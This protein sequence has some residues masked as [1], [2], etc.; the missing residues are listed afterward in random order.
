MA[1]SRLR[2]ID[3]DLPDEPGDEPV[4]PATPR[5]HVLEIVLEAAA[6]WLALAAFAP[7]FAGVRTF[8]LPTVVATVLATTLAVLARR[9]A[10]PTRFALVGSAVVAGLFVSYTILV[11]SLAWGVFPGRDTVSGLRRGIAQGFAQML[12]DSLP[13]GEHTLALVFV[14]LLGWAAAT[15][16]T[17]LVLRRGIPAL[18]LVVP[19]G[20]L[21]IAMPVVAPMHPPSAW[22]VG[23]LVVL[24]LVLALV[25]AVPDPEATG[26]LIGPATDGPAEFHSRSQVGA[27]LSLGL[28]FLVVAAL[29]AP[30]AADAVTSRRAADPRSLRDTVVQPLRVDDPLAEYARIVG[31]S[32]A[33]P[34]FQVT[35]QGATVAEVAR[36]A[37]VRLDTYDGVRFTTSD[38][39]DTAG[40]VLA[41][42]ADRPSSGRDVVLRFRNL[43]LDAPWLPTAGTP[44]RIDLRGVGYDR[45]S[46]DVLAPGTVNGLTYELQARIP[47]ATTA[48]LG[49]TPVDAGSDT[50]ADRAL[51]GGLPPNLGRVANEVT[52]GSLSPAEALEKLASYLR[53][54]FALDP[55][56]PSGHAAGRLDQFLRTDRAGTP[57]QF[58]TAFAV[59]ARS[60][61]Y[62]TRVVVGYKLLAD[63]NGAARPLEFVTTASYHVWAEVAYEGLGWI[64]YDP[65]PSTGGPAPA[66]G[67]DAAP[68]PETVTP[69][70]GGDQRTPRAVGPSEADPSEFAGSP[71][72]RPVAI[73]GGIAGG[74][75]LLVVGGCAAVIGAKLLRRR[76]RRAAG[77][78][79]GRV[80]GA[81]DE[82]V[83][84]LVELRFPIHPSMTPRDIARAT[85]AVYGTAAT[86]PLGFLVPD[87][88][89]AVFGQVAP[90]DDTADRSWAR[91]LEFE[92]NLAI[93]LNGRQRWRARLSLRPFGLGRRPDE[94]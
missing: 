90:D 49:A 12:A 88:G 47:T 65:T 76:R 80:V 4:R 56:A 38:E 7:V 85:Q 58:A 86:L 15:A 54:Q 75:V 57:E 66:R 48:D 55:R 63:D 69:T 77:D 29:V 34:A 43:D 23:G 89:R 1:M 78:A 22:H 35:V 3:E 32:P 9:R 18:P 8:V 26:T 6:C 10:V 79:A 53:T 72:W 30:V 64:P 62:P 84:R 91:A 74:A 13:L 40:P 19:L 60:L 41:Q 2:R 24:L 93:T 31:L 28:P 25:R 61:G 87:V 11:G 42:P 81:W 37:V 50:A 44:T 83:D 51:P 59:M 92:Q 67:T 20:V 45:S 70:A 21:A 39:Y 46:F 5:L 52:A 33:L 27:R 17:T 36:V 14:T 71:W 94:T 16:G 73:A 82:V 68:A